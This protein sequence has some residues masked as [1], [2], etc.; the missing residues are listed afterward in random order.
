[1][2]ENADGAGPAPERDLTWE[3]FRP[4]FRGEIPV[5]V[6]TQA[7]QVVLKTIVMLSDRFGFNVVLDHSTFDGYKTAPLVVERGI[8]TIVGPRQFFFDRTTRRINGIAAMYY[9]AGVRKLGIN[10]DAPVVPQ[11][12]L[13]LQAAIGCRLGLD[14]YVALRALT[15]APARALGVADLVGSLEVGKHAD[16]GVWTGDPIDPRRAC[17]KTFIQGRVVYDAKKKRRF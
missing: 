10:T 11:E 14:P 9:Q 1:M 16:F 12:E 7:Y 6:H 17:V 4:L 3:D 15:I 5:T 13:T 8:P 2:K